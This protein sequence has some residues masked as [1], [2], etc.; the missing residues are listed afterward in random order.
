MTETNFDTLNMTTVTVD[1]FLRFVR[2]SLEEEDMTP[3]IGIGKSGVGKTESIAGLCKE[4]GIGFC[5]LRL[6]TMTEVDLLG[7]PTISKYGTTTWAQNDLLPTIKDGE[8]GNISI[9]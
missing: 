6:V 4:M 3:I 8:R 5:E 9:R 1:R 2:E 7:I